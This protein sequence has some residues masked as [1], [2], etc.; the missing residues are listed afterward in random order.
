MCNV[1]INFQRIHTAIFQRLF[2]LIRK[3][4]IES[5]FWLIARNYF[6]KFFSP[7]VSLS[8]VFFFNQLISY[9]NKKKKKGIIRIF[10]FFFFTLLKRN[11]AIY[12]FD[13]IYLFAK[14]AFNFYGW[15]FRNSSVIISVRKGNRLF[16]HS[17]KMK[18]RDRKNKKE[19]R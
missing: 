13:T 1:Y 11:I 18:Y 9:D 3:R 7:L 17:P 8:H 2:I 6:L 16:V 14:C 5:F 15:I 19:G 10:F 4:A 12:R